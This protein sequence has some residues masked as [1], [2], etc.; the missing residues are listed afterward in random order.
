MEADAEIHRQALGQALVVQMKRGKR[1]YMSKGVKIMS[2]Q[3]KE[4]ADL[5][6][7]ELKD[8]GLASREWA[9]HPPALLHV[10]DSGS[11]TCP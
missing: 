1:D 8:S 2:Q 6:L 4:T 5:S 11:R 3:P 9:W 7:Q 10:D